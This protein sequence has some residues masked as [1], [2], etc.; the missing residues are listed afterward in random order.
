MPLNEGRIFKSVLDGHH[1]SD[2]SPSAVGGVHTVFSAEG[3]LLKMLACIA[4]EVRGA[5]FLMDLLLY[6]GGLAF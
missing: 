1:P 6:R 2:F 3:A 4:G 5:L